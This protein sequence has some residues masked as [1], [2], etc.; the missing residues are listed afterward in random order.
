[1]REILIYIVFMIF[2]SALTFRGLWDADIYAFGANIKGQLTGVEFNQEHS[3]TWG[4]TFN[5][6]AT[7]QEFYHWLYGPFAHTAFSQNT[8]VGDSAKGQARE[9]DGR[10]LGYGFTVGGVRIAQLRS[11]SGTCPSIP[12]QLQR[13]NRPYTCY[14]DGDG[15]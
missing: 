1:M 11:R 12:A 14:G 4:K 9:P 7:A 6:I 10:I 5:D 2:Y 8:F 3:P 13:P 15:D